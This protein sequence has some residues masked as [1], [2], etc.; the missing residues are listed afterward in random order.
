MKISQTASY[1]Q[2]LPGCTSTGTIRKHGYHHLYSGVTMSTLQVP[3][4]HWTRAKRL[5]YESMKP[6]LPKNLELGAS[7]E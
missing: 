3:A 5:R 6:E 1:G 4:S 7:R 2:A